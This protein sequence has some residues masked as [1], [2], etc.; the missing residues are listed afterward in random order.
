MSTSAIVLG[1]VIVTFI[2]GGFLVALFLGAR[3]TDEMT[4]LDE[5]AAGPPEE[6]P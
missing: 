3:P 6:T 1:I 4:G 5:P 2:L